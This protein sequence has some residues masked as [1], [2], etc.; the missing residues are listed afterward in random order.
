MQEQLKENNH[1]TL[2]GKIVETCKFS[3]EIYGE[4][5]YIFYLEVSRLSNI[6]D[7]LPITVSERLIDKDNLKMGLTIEITGQIRTYNNNINTKNHLVLTVF[8]KDICI[9]ND[10]KLKKNPNILELNGFICKKPIYRK[11][12]FG[13]EICDVLLAVNRSYNKSDYIPCIIWG[14]NAKFTSTLMISDNI[15]ISGRMQSRIYNKK[16]T[17]DLLDKIPPEDIKQGIKFHDLEDKDDNYHNPDEKFIEKVAY[18]ISVSKIELVRDEMK[19]NICIHSDD[20][21]LY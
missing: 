5:F 19:K 8:A 17:D 3:H 11:T 20:T 16:V 6:F 21:D 14:R 18:E 9:N 2:I 4:K 7:I 10:I 1:I 15:K 13:R 12:P